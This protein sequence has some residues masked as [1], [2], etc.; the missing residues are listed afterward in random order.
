MNNNLNSIKK[1]LKQLKNMQLNNKDAV[2]HNYVERRLNNIENKINNIY[3]ITNKSK[4]KKYA[5]IIFI[6]Y[7]IYKYYYY[8][9]N[10]DIIKETKNVTNNKIS[11]A[12][13][14]IINYYQQTKENIKK[15]IDKLKS[16]SSPETNQQPVTEQN[17]NANNNA[18][19]N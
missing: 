4:I 2:S 5:I 3:K 11:Q 15:Q 7:L 14:M 6:F 19:N 13:S 10:R 12:K 17:N 1:E 16:Q 8:I 18:N 9:K